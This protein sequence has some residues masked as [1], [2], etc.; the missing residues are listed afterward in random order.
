MTEV[1]IM[2]QT[3]GLVIFDPGGLAAFLARHQVPGPNVLEH[4]IQDP[5]LGNEALATGYVL[6]IYPIPAWDY[7]VRVTQA[8]QPSVPAEWVLFET[9][10]FVLQ[11]TSNQ[12][13]VSDLWA[14]LNWEAASYLRYG[15][16]SLDAAYAAANAF[17]VTEQVF[18]P[19]GR[20]QVTVV[21]FCDQ[22]QADVET[23]PC[24]YELLLTPNEQA[25]FGMLG[26]IASLDLEVVKLPE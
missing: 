20:Y 7:L 2:T 18:V 1:K 4:F 3:P 23:R 21:G 15:Q 9:P 6:P 24:G 5:S 16:Q 11:V 10:A 13:L 17:H 22:Q 12:V 19:N 26:S 25:A 8:A 14:L